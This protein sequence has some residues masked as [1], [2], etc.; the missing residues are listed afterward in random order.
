MD[1]ITAHRGARDQC[2]GRGKVDN[3]NSRFIFWCR[4]FNFWVLL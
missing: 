3:E 4:R 1:S 2:I